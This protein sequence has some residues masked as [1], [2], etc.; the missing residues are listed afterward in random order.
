MKTQKKRIVKILA[1]VLI[2]GEIAFVAFWIMVITAYA[3]PLDISEILNEDETPLPASPYSYTPTISNAGSYMLCFLSSE[4]STCNIDSAT[5]DGD[6]MTQLR[7][8]GSGGSLKWYGLANPSTGSNTL[9]ITH[10]GTCSA[11]AYHVC[12]EIENISTTTVY[13]EYDGGNDL[14]TPNYTYSSLFDISYIIQT[15]SGWAQ[16]G[17]FTKQIETTWASNRHIDVASIEATSTDPHY[18]SWTSNDGSTLTWFFEFP[19]ELY[20]T[21]MDLIYP[22]GSASYSIWNWTGWQVEWGFSSGALAAYDDA[23]PLYVGIDDKVAGATSSQQII[24]DNW[25]TI[26]DITD[27]TD[28]GAI[29]LAP[30]PTQ[31]GEHTT[32]AEIT[33]YCGGWQ[34]F[35]NP[36]NTWN[37]STSSYD[38]PG[39]AYPS[40]WCENICDDLATSS[41]WW[42]V[43]GWGSAIECAGRKL[44]C[45]TTTLSPKAYDSVNDTMDIL[46]ARP[47]FV[48][49]ADIQ[50]IIASTSDHISN[51]SQTMLE[52]Q[53]WPT[54]SPTPI[55]DVDIIDGVV[56]EE[57]RLAIRDL[58]GYVMWF[59]W[60]GALWVWAMSI[61]KK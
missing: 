55:I 53:I 16:D 31:L 12:Y 24:W 35:A 27:E 7:A 34:T 1:R 44:V 45:W 51:E 25:G 8:D 17:Y 54:A 60:V 23:C 4:Q 28:Y 13:T 46:A 29:Y 49:M 21:F 50:N 22:A 10:T 20:T 6:S 26:G 38:N 52:W 30:D 39:I 15:G 47:P 41:A 9:S 36:C 3:A 32:C 56:G 40:A 5:Y 19:P 57:K 43:S 61:I 18:S 59:S 11:T 2:V 48:I 58:T 33:T 14:Y 37:L 42:D